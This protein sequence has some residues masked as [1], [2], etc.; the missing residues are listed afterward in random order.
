[1]KQLKVHNHTNADPRDA[2]GNARDFHVLIQFIGTVLVI[3]GSTYYLGQKSDSIRDT[4]D[5]QVAELR[6]E[7]AAELRQQRSENA[8]EFRLLRADIKE[9]IERVTRLED[10]YRDEE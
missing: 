9:L 5:A 8:A 6:Q 2:N 4:V 10:S 7:T 1:M 3:L